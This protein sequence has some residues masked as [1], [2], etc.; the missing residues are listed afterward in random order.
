MSKITPPSP[1]VAMIQGVAKRLVDAGG[2]DGRIE[3]QEVQR[4]LSRM[5]LGE[6]ELATTFLRIVDSFKQAPTITSQD[7]ENATTFMKD[8]IEAKKAREL[9]EATKREALAKLVVE[10][11]IPVEFID[12]SDKE[13]AALTKSTVDLAK[14]LKAAANSPAID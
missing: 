6:R 9:S 4:A 8:A 3:P 2:T 11:N 10:Y 1:T 7:V 5:P 12:L 13:R 14:A